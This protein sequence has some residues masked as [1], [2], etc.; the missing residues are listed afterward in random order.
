LNAQLLRDAS[1]RARSTSNEVHGVTSQSTEEIDA[2]RESAA[3]CAVWAGTL[4]IP[5]ALVGKLAGVD[6]VSVDRWLDVQKI[7]SL[8]LDGKRYLPRYAFDE[9]WQPLDSIETPSLFLDNARPRDLVTK[10]AQLLVACAQ[11][12]VANEHYAG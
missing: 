8:Q 1:K 6:N 2:E 5:K 4:W 7:F 12:C 11:D 10:D 9:R 3:I